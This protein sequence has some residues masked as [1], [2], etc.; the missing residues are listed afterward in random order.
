[1]KFYFTLN[2]F[3]AILPSMDSIIDGSN[4]KLVNMAINKVKDNNIPKAAVLPKSESEK[5]K[6]P[7]N[8]IILV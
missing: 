2:N 5:I 1:M 3:F 8:K 4:N 6:K 7:A